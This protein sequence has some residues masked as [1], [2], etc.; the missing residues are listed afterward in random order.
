[1]KSIEHYRQEMNGKWHRCEKLQCELL[2]D[3]L[4]ELRSLN[5]HLENQEGGQYHE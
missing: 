1:M 2:I 5:R 4:A 3:I